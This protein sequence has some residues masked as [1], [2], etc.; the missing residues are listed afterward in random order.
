MV[1][2]TGADRPKLHNT[3]RVVTEAGYGISGATANGGHVQ[4]G[5]R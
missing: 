1:E 4:H 5:V 3:T 2:R